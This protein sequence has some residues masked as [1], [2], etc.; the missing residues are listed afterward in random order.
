MVKIMTTRLILGNIITLDDIKPNVEA[1]VVEDGIIKYIG[2]RKTAETLCDEDTEIL[3]FGDNCI[4]PG[5]IE[6]HAHGCEAGRALGLIPPL[7]EGETMDDYV[8]I[9]K[10]VIE[11]NPDKDLYRG[12]GWH[13]IDKE[14][15]A[16]MLD[17]IC[18]DKPISLVSGDGHSTWLNTKAMEEFGV[19]KNMVEKYGAD[20]CRV[21]EDGNPTGWLSEGP[22]YEVQSKTPLTIEEAKESILLWQQYCFANGYVAAFDAG[23][24]VYSENPIY[25]YPQLE[26]EGKLKLRTFAGIIIPDNI[27]DVDSKIKEIADYASKYNKEY[28]KITTSK[29]FLDGVI[30][31]DTGLLL[32]EYNHKP[33]YYGVERFSNH[34]KFVEVVCKSGDYGLNVHCHSDGDGAVEF[35]LNGFAEAIAAGYTDQRNLLAH[36]HL[37]KPYHFEQFADYN[38]TSVTPPLWVPLV[39]VTAK[40]EIETIGAERMHAGYPINSFIKAGAN[41]VFHTDF[42]VSPIMN[43]G[44]SIFIAV[45]RYAPQ[46]YGVE[47]MGPESTKGP[48]EAIT[49]IQALEALTKNVAYAYHQEDIMGTLSVGKIANMVV[50]KENFLED[51]LEEIAAAET[52]YTLVDGE[53]VYQK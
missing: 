45:T 22:N 8:A 42:P 44:M 33:E 10:K 39:D 21:D 13:I 24:D 23:I 15:T 53:I 14:P 47:P 3:D 30:E 1:L 35:A 46:N 49:R 40:R 9:M 20:C 26:E 18:S 19:D 51:D 27:E 31:V 16:A 2:S 5:F 28:F 43:A 17:E 38:V 52:L 4:Y 29:V 41:N 7:Y 50:F 12:I 32:E 36:L 34:D 48:E 6:A 37:V 25:A 11:E